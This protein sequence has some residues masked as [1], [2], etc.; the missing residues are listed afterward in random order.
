MRL[1][2][3]V[4]LIPGFYAL[5]CYECVADGKNV[6]NGGG[7]WFFEKIMAMGNSTVRCKAGE[8]CV[9]WWKEQNPRAEPDRKRDCGA[10][11]PH[12]CGYSES[13]DEDVVHRED[14]G[15]MMGCGCEGP[16]CNDWDEITLKDMAEATLEPREDVLNMSSPL[17]VVSIG[18]TYHIFP[19]YLFIFL[20]AF[21]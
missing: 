4:L 7:G 16:L 18:T 9:W 19:Y 15:F 20:L 13:D 6:C 21:A 11:G 17:P 10:M 2:A 3:L 8:R 5:L 12:R 1:L 14:D